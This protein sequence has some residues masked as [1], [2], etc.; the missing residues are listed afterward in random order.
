MSVPPTRSPALA[1]F[2]IPELAAHIG[3]YLRPT[4][5]QRLCLVSKT[6]YV[7]FPPSLHISMSSSFLP[8]S[9]PPLNSTEIQALVS[10]IRGL[11][12]NIHDDQTSQ[13]QIDLLN[14]VY[15]HC[16]TLETLNIEYQGKD[17]AVLKD[18]LVILPRIR[19]LS[20]TFMDNIT[21]KIAVQ[22]LVGTRNMISDGNESGCLQ[23]LEIDFGAQGD[24]YLA[25]SHLKQLLRSYP[26]LKSLSLSGVSFWKRTRGP[27]T[28]DD[29]DDND[30]DY[31]EI[32]EHDKSSQWPRRL[33]QYPKMERL[34]FN[35]CTLAEDRLIDM[36]K[37]FPWLQTLEIIGC[38]GTWQTVLERPLPTP[39][40][41]PSAATTPLDS[42]PQ[43]KYS[44]SELRRLVIWLEFQSG[45]SELVNLVRGRPYLST[46]E[47]DLLPLRRGG[48]L[49]L[50]E[51]SSD[52]LSAESTTKVATAELEKDGDAAPAQNRFKRLGIQTYSS[53]PLTTE[54]LDQ[55][56]G[57][58]CFK[59]LDYVFMQCRILTMKRFPFAKTLRSL[60][61]GG[62]EECL[63]HDE[64]ATLRNILLQLPVLEVLRI[65]RYIDSYK[66]FSGLGREPSSTLPDSDQADLT[67]GSG[68]NN[69]Q[70][71]TW[72][73]ESP[74]LYDLEFYVRLPPELAGD[75][76]EPTSLAKS[77]GH[78]M[79]L[80]NLQRQVLDRFRFLER[81]KL[82]M[83]AGNRRFE[84]P[85]ADE[86]VAW[87]KK[88]QEERGEG[89][90]LPLVEFAM[91]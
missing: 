43:T 72:M 4:Q 40:R 80:E 78:T 77:D 47:T 69:I 26:D 44:F 56:Y 19:N 37:L 11:S 35:R 70:D 3:L 57:S 2:S 30:N 27:P 91:R 53:P 89:S 83:K 20:L 24:R 41:H 36:D 9:K 22:T 8:L 90:R 60:Y 7:A 84:L 21:T 38:G 71:W 29:D 18:V 15:K 64:E 87:K 14:N 79:S 33:R 86:L 81:L 65:D 63:S 68:I 55:F 12:L 49:A 31:E 74:F 46:L 32:L 52:H 58:A 59:E 88:V 28:S 23:S 62:V 48:L 10:R 85:A 67:A 45:R 16:A 6:L 73:N 1:V 17:V 82:H 51:Y 42:L 34:K 66:L 5:R 76:S 50:A 61:L 13:I 25:W 75:T 39:W 54:V